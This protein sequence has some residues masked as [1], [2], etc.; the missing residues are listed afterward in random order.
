MKR[1][2]GGGR[3]AREWHKERCGQRKREERDRHRGRGRIGTYHKWLYGL[4]HTLR[5][6]VSSYS[7]LSF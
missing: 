2:V 3:E 6:A 5:G 4:G 7:I 1:D